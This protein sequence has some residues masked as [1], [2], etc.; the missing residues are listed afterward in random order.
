MNGSNTPFYIWIGILAFL[1]IASLVMGG[2]CYGGI[3]A[4]LTGNVPP[5]PTSTTP[6]KK[7]GIAKADGHSGADLQLYEAQEGS[8]YKYE[9]RNNNNQAIAVLQLP[10][11]AKITNNQKIQV[12]TSPPTFYRVQLN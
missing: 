11:G 5:S 10:Q 3:L 6:F 1:L 9:L 2:L 4:P 12:P 7:M 8:A